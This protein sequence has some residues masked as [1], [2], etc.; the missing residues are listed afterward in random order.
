MAT[1]TWIT[2]GV[3]GFLGVWIALGV[4]ASVVERRE[5]RR[6]RR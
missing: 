2:L 1:E 6:K 5:E 3:C 4:I